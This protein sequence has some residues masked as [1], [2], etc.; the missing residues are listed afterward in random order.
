MPVDDT[1][2]PGDAGF[3]TWAIS[4]A[5][6]LNQLEVN[7]VSKTIVD[8]VGDL[9]VATAPDTVARFAKGAGGTFLGVAEGTEE[10]AWLVPAGGGGGGLP[11][12]AQYEFMDATA[13]SG[14]SI[15]AAFT[16]V[17]LPTEVTDT[18]GNYDPATYFYTVPTTGIYEITG[19]LRVPDSV[20]ANKQMGVGVHTSNVDGPWFLWY[21][22]GGATRQTWPYIRR[23]RFTAGEQLRMYAY[24]DSA[25]MSI[26]AASMQISLV[27]TG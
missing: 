15:G 21:A 19:T 9:I 12:E 18:G 2:A 7:Q 13:G 25:G 17:A 16:T 11:T 24:S 6:L 10:L 1:I 23:A 4:V 26:Q 27:A 20:G 5:Q 14:Q 3:A 8:A 22:V